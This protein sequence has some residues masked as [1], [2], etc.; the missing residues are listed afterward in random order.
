V[1][2]KL[3]QVEMF[4]GLRGA[5]STLV[6]C[7]GFTEGYYYESTAKGDLGVSAAPQ[8]LS[9]AIAMTVPPFISGVP[10][11]FKRRKLAA[12][13]DSGFFCP[14]LNSSPWSGSTGHFRG[15]CT[16]SPPKDGS[17]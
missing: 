16:P 2:A 4:T 11:E 15:A 5:M 8:S 17:R 12:R 13:D 7:H 6:G 14:P 9:G 1:L 3:C 10:A